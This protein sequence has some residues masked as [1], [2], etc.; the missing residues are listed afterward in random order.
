M[1]TR[2]TGSEVKTEVLIIP[3]I[4]KSSFK[5]TILELLEERWALA[6][7]Q[8]SFMTDKNL[9]IIHSS[10]SSLRKDGLVYT[11]YDWRVRLTIAGEWY[12]RE[13]EKLN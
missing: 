7:K 13:Y 3:K 9:N 11:G 10:L 8:I 2:I 12:I 1:E 5:F 4:R 6:P